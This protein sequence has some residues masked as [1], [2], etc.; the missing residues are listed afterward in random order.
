MPNIPC[1]EPGCP[2]LI[3]DPC[4]KLKGLFVIHKDLSERVKNTRDQEQLGLL[5]SVEQLLEKELGLNTN[6]SKFFLGREKLPETNRPIL[7]TLQC[8][9][10]HIHQYSITCQS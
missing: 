7:F 4:V 6:N 3:T 5:N 9:R 2:S 8:I 1:K 10:G